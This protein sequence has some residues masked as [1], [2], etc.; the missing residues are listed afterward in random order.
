MFRSWYLTFFIVSLNSCNE[1]GFLAYCKYWHLKIHR[2]LKCIK[3]SPNI[4]WPWEILHPCSLWAHIFILFPVQNVFL[5]P[6]NLLDYPFILLCN[7]KHF[8]FHLFSHLAKWQHYVSRS[9]KQY[10]RSHSFIFLTH[11]IHHQVLVTLPLVSSTIHPRLS[12]T[13]G[14]TRI[15]EKGFFSES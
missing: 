4:I 8:I 5:V 12:S 7:P 2:T 3:R 6:A 15:P 13:Q 1:Y 11:P 14:S 10:L 9:S